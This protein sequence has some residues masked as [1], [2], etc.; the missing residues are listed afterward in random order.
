[1]AQFSICISHDQ[2]ATAVHFFTSNLGFDDGFDVGSV[3]GSVVGSFSST[4]E[5]NWKKLV[6]KKIH[7]T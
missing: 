1:M 7:V 3:V 5:K 2:N 4:S 6:S